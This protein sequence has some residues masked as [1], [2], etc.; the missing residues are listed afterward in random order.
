MYCAGKC[1][2]LQVIPQRGATRGRICLGKARPEAIA[3][4][5]AKAGSGITPVATSA[6]SAIAQTL[7]AA[8]VRC[9]SRFASPSGARRRK[10]GLIASA[11][12]RSTTV[13]RSP[14]TTSDRGDRKSVVQG[15]SGS[16]R[17]NLG[18]GGLI[19]KK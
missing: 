4:T 2:G 6:M 12:Q 3:R 5:I 18:G 13:L 7:A 9:H 19:Q 8:S 11:E 15:K 14:G 10:R 17:V 1:I 16:I